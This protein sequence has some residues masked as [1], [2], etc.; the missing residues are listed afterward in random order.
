MKKLLSTLPLVLMIMGC[1][2]APMSADPSEIVAATE[3]WEAALNAKDVDGIVALYTVSASR[4]LLEPPDPYQPRSAMAR[5]MT[6][7]T[8]PSGARFDRPSPRAGTAVVPHFVASERTNGQSPMGETAV[9]PL[10]RGPVRSL[11]GRG[12]A[13]I[14]PGNPDPSAQWSSCREAHFSA[15]CARPQAS[16]RIPGPQGDGRRPQ[17]PRPAPRQGTQASVRISKQ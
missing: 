12:A 8:K 9:K 2:Q 4:S 3:A 11:T 6:S 5:A 7:R 15:Q 1:N 10:S 13:R 14:Q 17:D 16:P